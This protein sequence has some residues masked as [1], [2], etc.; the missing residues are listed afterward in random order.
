MI[1]LNVQTLASGGLIERIQEEI[2]R[3]IANICDP[4]TPA[5]K[6]RTVTMKMTIKPNEP[7]N[8]ADVSVLVSSTLCPAEPIETGIYIGQDVR[9]GEVSA[10][11]V[12]S[13]EIPNQNMLPEMEQVIPGKIA[14]FPKAQ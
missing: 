2:Q 5:K 11:E 3:A 6:A 7:R 14:R 4:N 9:T 8:M 10:S 1:Q 12:V 13:G